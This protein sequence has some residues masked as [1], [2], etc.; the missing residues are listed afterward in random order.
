MSTDSFTPNFSHK[1]PENLGKSKIASNA[2]YFETYKEAG[3][4]LLAPYNVKFSLL[5]SLFTFDTI[6]DK[7]NNT[8]K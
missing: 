6:N 1:K 3:I 4:I 5:T 8:I 7:Y 2:K